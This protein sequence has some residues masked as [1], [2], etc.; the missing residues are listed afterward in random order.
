MLLNENTYQ[1]QSWLSEYCRSGSTNGLLLVREE[2]LPFYR[3]LVFNVINEAIEST[4]PIAFQHIDEKIWSEMI[5]KFFEK[6]T[7]RQAQVWRMPKEFYEF[8][9]END[10]AG[11]YNLPFLNDLLYFE[12]MEAEMYVMED[13]KYPEYTE[14]IN[15]QDQKIAVNPEHKIVSF[16]YP[17]HMFR[18]NEAL[19]KKGK[20]FL[21]FYREKESGR[22]QF[23][24]LSVL[25][26]FLLENIAVAEKEL[27]SIINDI[28][29]IFGI[30]DLELLVSEINK[31]LNDLYKKSFV[32]GILK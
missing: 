7:C 27:E 17:V 3:R 11:K 28:L 15:W 14:T 20:Y 9:K 32:L 13:I 18:P 1:Q 6:H 26:A 4:F 2:R 12:W 19:G 25:F 8:C 5:F 22:I 16:D 21:L 23:V 30:N 29:Y 31:F 10:Y 24:N